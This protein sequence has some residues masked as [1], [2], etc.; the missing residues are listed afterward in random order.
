MTDVGEDLASWVQ[1]LDMTEFLSTDGDDGSD[2]LIEPVVPAGAAVAIWARAKVGKSLLMLDLCCALACG[3]SLLGAAAGTAADV[4][5]FD[6]ENPA[7]DLRSRFFDLGYT[8]ESNLKRLHYYHLPSLP[9]LDTPLGGEVVAAQVNRFGAG[10]VV[11]DTTASTVMG[12]ENDADTYRNFYRHTGSRIRAMGAALVRLDHGGKDRTKG[13][14]GSSAKDDDVDVIWEMYDQGA[15]LVLRRTRSRIPW[16]PPEVR[17]DRREEPYLRHEL[18]PVTL[19]AEVIDLAGEMD[20]LGLPLDV[21]KRAAMDALRKAG[22]GR[23]Q[24]DVLAAI[25]YRNR[26]H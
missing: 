17:L 24:G 11:I 20:R 14:R 8:A 6:M 4:C 7:G 26:P 9:P 10:L 25:K 22:R 2:W 16:V 18:A 12:G 21:S 23:R 15:Q 13:Q 1:P 19:P 3:R 5:Y